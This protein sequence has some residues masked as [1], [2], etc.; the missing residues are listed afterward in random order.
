MVPSV[1]E[2]YELLE[3]DNILNAYENVGTARS[4]FSSGTSPDSSKKKARVAT[5]HT[6][7][8]ELP[9]KV[10]RS[11]REKPLERRNVSDF[12][13]GTSSAEQFIIEAICDD[14]FYTISELKLILA[15]KL[16]G[17]GPGWWRI[18]RILWK[19]NLLSKRSRFRY[20]R[21]HRLH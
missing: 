1:L 20:A 2:I 21:Q 7:I 9:F 15:E 18:F 5:T 12:S 8:E 10:D 6:T 17:F 4:A 3:F 13:N 14:P 19:K 11:I 16:P